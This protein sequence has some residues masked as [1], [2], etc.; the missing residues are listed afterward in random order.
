MNQ[1][2]VIAAVLLLTGCANAASLTSTTVPTS[3]SPADP[4]ITPIVL[5]VPGVTWSPTAAATST[6]TPAPTSTPL[7]PTTLVITA[8]Q[9]YAGP[10]N[11]G[12]AML[13]QLDEGQHV[14][15]VGSFGD[16]V[17]IDAEISG[18]TKSGFVLKDAVS[19]LPKKLGLLNDQ[20]VPW[21]PVVDSLRL[22]GWELSG[23]N[24]QNGEI[25][26]NSDAN[27]YNTRVDLYDPML[28]TGTFAIR[29]QF[30]GTGD[31]Y[32]VIIYGTTSKQSPWWKGIRRLDVDSSSGDLLLNFY[33]GTSITPQSFPLPSAL[34]GQPL[35]LQFEGVG[36]QV[37]VLNSNGSV[38]AKWKLKAALFPDHIFYLGVD[39]GLGSTLTVSELQV[40]VPPTGKQLDLLPFV[41][42]APTDAEGLRGLADKRG[43]ELGA[44]VQWWRVFEKQYGDTFISNYNVYSSSDFLWRGI[45]PDPTRYNFDSADR[46]VKLAKSHQMRVQAHHLVWGFNYALP[47]WLVSGSYTGT[48]LLGVLHDHI[49]TIV[50]RYKGQVK[51]W[52]VVNEPLTNDGFFAP[53]LGQAYIELA[54]RWAHAA[55]P[56]AVLILNQDS[57]EDRR[58][59][60]TQRI[61]DEL[62]DLVRRLKQKGVPIDGIGMEMHL[63]GAD[64]PN[65]HGVLDNMRRFGA[66]GVKVYVTEFD[67]NLAGMQG[68]L[69][70]K[71]TRQASIYHDMLDACI[72]SRVCPSFTSHGFRDA[73]SWLLDPKLQHDLGVHG[74]APLPF[75]DDYYPK[76]AYF[77]MRDVLAANP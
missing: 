41:L 3:T 18:T 11:L 75:S 71:Y 42:R 52:S 64:P 21:L 61:S 27:G 69:D 4:T 32:G 66:L 9:L 55:D 58:N 34:S 51:E 46:V 59:A 28:I 57:D 63:N 13:G 60:Y 49:N 53:R 33:D 45:Q 2:L 72:E 14:S 12:Y 19:K 15:P 16:F 62:Y 47:D 26:L 20:Q 48:K 36:E 40:S 37:S 67:V 68:T 65:K 31:N 5:S 29:L 70:E 6:H 8:T 77:A 56:Q 44:N 22:T 35:T 39:S 25:V 43:F 54:F 74:E 73:D 38:A 17:Q 7:A 1:A 50:S 24:L 10:G 30:S 23:V 76:P